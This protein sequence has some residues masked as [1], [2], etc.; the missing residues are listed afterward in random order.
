MSRHG[1]TTWQAKDAALQVLPGVFMHCLSGSQWYCPSMPK[2]PRKEGKQEVLASEN[3]LD[4][5][6]QCLTTKSIHL[7]LCTISNIRFDVRSC[8]QRKLFILS[9]PFKDPFSQAS[10]QVSF[11]AD[12]TARK[13]KRAFQIE[14][15]IKGALKRIPK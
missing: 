9:G 8:K 4:R 11:K 13:R 5:S 3:S 2:V 6:G 12:P 15:Y 14:V 7:V 1:L 10:G